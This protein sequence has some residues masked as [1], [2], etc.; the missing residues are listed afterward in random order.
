[1]NAVE[2]GSR[3]PLSFN[4]IFTKANT[5]LLIIAFVNNVKNKSKN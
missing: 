1:M 5:R 4:A 2:W 3:L